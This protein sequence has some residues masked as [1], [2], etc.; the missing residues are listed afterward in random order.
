MEYKK[1]D[2]VYIEYGFKVIDGKITNRKVEGKIINN[3]N[4]FYTVEAEGKEFPM[5]SEYDILIN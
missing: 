2:K 5:M 4:G 3:I 1:G